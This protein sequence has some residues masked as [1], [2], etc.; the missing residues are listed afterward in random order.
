MDFQE[1]RN[2]RIFISSTFEDMSI[3]R[4]ELAKTFR[5]LSIKARA[6]NASLHAIDLRWGIRPG[7]SVVEL[8]L[9]EIENSQPFFLG[10]VGERYGTT[11]PMSEFRENKNLQIKYGKWL[12]NAFDMGMSYTEIEMEFGAFMEMEKAESKGHIVFF[13]KDS[14]LKDGNSKILNLINK[15][16]YYQ[17]KGLCDVD[18]YSSVSELVDKVRNYYEN[19]LNTLFPRSQLKNFQIERLVQKAILEEKAVTYIPY[20]DYCMKLDAFIE[21]NN[22]QYC[23]LTGNNGVGKSSLLAHWLKLHNEDDAVCFIYNF[24]GE[25][26]LK[27]NVET[28]REQIFAEVSDQF[29]II[30]TKREISAKDISELFSEVPTDKL[31]ILVLDGV[32]KLFRNA[33]NEPVNLEWLPIPIDS[34]IKLIMSDVPKDILTLSF[35]KQQCMIEIES[36]QESS[37]RIKLIDDF[38]G[39]YGK[40]LSNEGKVLL[41]NSDICSNCFILKTI[42]N[43]LIYFGKHDNV[44]DIINWFIEEDKENTLF[45]KLLIHYENHYSTEL[46]KDVLS[47]LAVSKFGL[48][49]NDII[50]ILKIRQLD[51]SQ[52]FCALNLHLSQN[53]GKIRFAHQDIISAVEKRYGNILW[54]YRKMLAEYYHDK[55]KD[56]TGK[57]N[58]MA[59]LEVTYQYYK[60]DDS[61]DLYYHLSDFQQCNILLRHDYFNMGLYWRYL[62]EVDSNRYTI[63]V[64][65]KTADRITEEYA[66]FLRSFSMFCFD[67]LCDHQTALKYME[68]CHN[69]HAKLFGEQSVEV[70]VDYERMGDIVR[71]T[72]YLNDPL[73]QALEYYQEAYEILIELPGNHKKD[74]F[75]NLLAMGELV[76]QLNIS[77]NDNYPFNKALNM[78]NELE[79]DSLTIARII[80]DFANKKYMYGQYKEA[81]EYYMDSIRFRKNVD[82]PSHPSIANIYISIGKTYEAEGNYSK[83]IEYYMHAKNMMEE[84]FGE[85]H[86]ACGRVY[87]FI[88]R[89]LCRMHKDE[90]GLMYIDDAINIWNNNLGEENAGSA[91]ALLFKAKV[92]AAMENNDEPSKQARIFAEKA[93][94]IYEKLGS[95]NDKANSGYS[96]LAAMYEKK[97]PKIAE[98]YL[99][100]MHPFIGKID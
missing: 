71:S 40:K 26:V 49:E 29:G 3:E 54:R 7:E 38:L 94:E 28:I 69:A 99:K 34:K 44:S 45:D 23:V 92:Y 78:L 64:Y 67:V 12:E 79:G 58:Y 15:I 96:F 2:I 88:G 11:P 27:Y 84:L 86:D 76:D 89:V 32:S 31:L 8:C 75:D 95:L 47:L 19:E 50:A 59:I 77:P 72:G 37:E 20:N 18:S 100:R 57:C 5:E 80:Q 24:I 13:V 91:E 41:A 30:K 83:T 6:Y 90:E 17:D 98:L 46:V 63:T 36:L 68:L 70:A 48:E 65:E 9:N 55:V 42:L 87:Y 39:D 21:D 74:I 35:F 16:Q 60:L 62:M 97:Y 22:N 56:D 51:W 25:G 14:A 61:E 1:K 82:H 4:S 43:E 85:Q 93:I 66:M 73:G 81:R 33:E 10:I 52:L 53:N